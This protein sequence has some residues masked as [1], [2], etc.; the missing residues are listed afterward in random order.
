MR[1]AYADAPLESQ[2]VN[3]SQIN[4]F[5]IHICYLTLKIISCKWSDPRRMTSI[6]IHVLVDIRYKFD[7]MGDLEV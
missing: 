6:V 2:Y 5:S 3:L 7:R 1:D 4:L